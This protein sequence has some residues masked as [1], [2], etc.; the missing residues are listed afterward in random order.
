MARHLLKEDRVG[1]INRLRAE[2]VISDELGAGLCQALQEASL[3]EKEL[4]AIMRGARAVPIKRALPNPRG[5]S[6][7]TAKI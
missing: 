7:T 1:E 2:A 4:Q 3:H 6:S 5:P